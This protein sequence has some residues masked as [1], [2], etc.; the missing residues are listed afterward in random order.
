MINTKQLTVT[1]WL[2]SILISVLLSQSITYL[3]ISPIFNKMAEDYSNVLQQVI[4]LNNKKEE[5]EQKVV[6][7][8][9]KLETSMTSVE[10]VTGTEMSDEHKIFLIKIS[11]ILTAVL[12]SGSLFAYFYFYWKGLFLNNLLVKGLGV[13]NTYALTFFNLP[14]TFF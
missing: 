7:L 4:A 11:L 10:V 3:I 5:L 2:L 9:K 8:E 13:L 1:T 14:K 12:I 6:I